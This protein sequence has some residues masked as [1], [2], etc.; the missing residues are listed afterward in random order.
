M[1]T[2][3]CGCGYGHMGVGVVVDICVWFVGVKL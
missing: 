3:V 2:Y 1:W